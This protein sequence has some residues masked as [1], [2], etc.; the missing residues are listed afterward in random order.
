MNDTILFVNDAFLKTYGYIEHEILGKHIN[1]IGSPNNSPD[2][3][4]E[5]RKAAR[6]TGWHGEMLNR[7]KDGREFYVSLSTSVVRDDIGRAIALVGVASD[8]TD[9][10]ITEQVQ[11]LLSTALESTA[12][13]V[14]ITD[15]KGNIEWVNK[16]FSTMTGY[17]ATE[18][19]GK[20]PRILKSG[21]QDDS[22]YQQLWQTITAG[23]VWTGELINKKKDGILYADETTIT[24]LRDKNG[25]VTNFIAIKQDVTERK[26]AQES[27]ELFRTLVDNAADSIEVIDPD[28]GRFLEANEKAW[29][30]L[31]Y[32]REE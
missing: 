18:V 31:G 5:L 26:R 30:S 32:S 21:E 8:I 10:K 16:A 2:L 9:R 6:E 12:N 11:L 4:N 14:V 7:A 1:I 29:Q 13:G 28:T 19:W 24:P 17:T 23:N 27:L 3:L 22:Y 20:N 15:S 25:E